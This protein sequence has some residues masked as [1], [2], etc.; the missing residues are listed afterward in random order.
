M[1]KS[2]EAPIRARRPFGIW[3]LTGFAVVIAGVLPIYSVILF[4]FFDPGSSLEVA[5]ILTIAFTLAVS[6]GVVFTSVGAW[7]GRNWARKSLLIFITLFYAPQV[8]ISLIFI[9]VYKEPDASSEAA[10]QQL[11]QGILTVA[12][13]IWYFNRARVKKFYGVGAGDEAPGKY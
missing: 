9:F 11:L 13:F 12:V 2:T 1:K 5:S 6:L 8:I 7:L 3:A 10:R 4:V